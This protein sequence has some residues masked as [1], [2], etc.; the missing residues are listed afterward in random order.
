M[1]ADMKFSNRFTH[2]HQI[3]SFG[4]NDGAPI[5]TITGSGSGASENLR[6]DH[7]GDGT[8]TT[9]LSR[10]P[11]AGIKG[12]WLEVRETIMVADNGS[13]RMTVKKPD[14]TTVIDIK[15]SGLDFWRQGECV[16]AKWEIYRGKSDQLKVGEETLRFA[17][18]GIT[19]GATPSSDCRAK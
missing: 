4:G 8:A 17:N 14:G 10:R 18:F 1:N 7:G 11:T 5:I 12:I 16:R 6:V 13:I 3:K 19:K 9:T 2:M 15:Q